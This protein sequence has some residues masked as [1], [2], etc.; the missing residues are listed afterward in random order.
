MPS[1]TTNLKTLYH[2]ANKDMSTTYREHINN[3]IRKMYTHESMAESD[4][5]FPLWL[6]EEPP[7]AES[8]AEPPADDTIPVDD[9]ENRRAASE[10]SSATVVLKREFAEFMKLPVELRLKI[11]AI[12]AFN[13]DI[14]RTVGIHSDRW[15][16]RGH[17]AVHTQDI[18]SPANYVAQACREAR[19]EVKRLSRCLPTSFLY[20]LGTNVPSMSRKN[21]TLSYYFNMDCRYYHRDTK[22]F[23]EERDALETFYY[24]AIHKLAVEQLNWLR[25]LVLD[26]LTFGEILRE[27]GDLFPHCGNGAPFKLL[28]NLRTITVAFLFRAE[29]DIAMLEG[30]YNEMVEEL[31]I[32]REE[33]NGEAPETYNISVSNFQILLGP[34]KLV[35]GVMSSY[36]S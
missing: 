28:P 24:L 29:H 15:G 11:Y 32:K 3:I 21:V 31:Q 5:W 30:V 13:W 7:P 23:L 9:A 1:P 27:S 16:K 34:R 12:A 35:Y 14:V 22:F 18:P 6:P 25:H 17:F 10:D 33:G 26:H 2:L 4:T 36:P 19:Y 20:D 8:P